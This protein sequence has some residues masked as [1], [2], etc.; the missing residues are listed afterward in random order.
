MIKVGHLPNFDVKTGEPL[1]QTI[2]TPD[3]GMVKV[4]GDSRLSPQVVA[5]VNTIK[6]TDKHTYKLITAMG[7]AE[8]WGQNRNGDRFYER[9]LLLPGPKYGHT[10]FLS[11]GVYRHHVNKDPNKSLG[12]VIF[13]YYNHQMHRVELVIDYDHGLLERHGAMDYLSLTNPDYS[14]AARVPWDRCTICNDEALFRKVLAGAVSRR[15]EDEVRAVLDYIKHTPIK[16]LATKRPDYCDHLKHM[17]NQIIETGPDAGKQVGSKNDYPEFFDIS[18]VTT[19]ADPSAKEMRKIASA[20]EYMGGAELAEY[21]G[22]ADEEPYTILTK[23]ASWTD[24]LEIART[25][26]KRAADKAAMLEHE[27]D[28]DKMVDGVGVPLSV[29]QER[30]LPRELLGNGDV[31]RL[32]STLGG[33]GIVLNPMEFQTMSLDRMGMGGLGSFLESRNAVFPPCPV[34]GGHAANMPWVSPSSV[35]RGLADSFLPFLENRSCLTPVSDRRMYAIFVKTAGTSVHD[36]VTYTDAVQMAPELE[37]TMSAVGSMYRAYRENLASSVE[38]LVHSACGFSSVRDALWGDALEKRAVSTVELA[39][40]GSLFPI[41]YLY[42]AH[43]RKEEQ[44]G[45]RLGLIRDFLK[46]HPM[47]SAAAVAGMLKTLGYGAAKSAGL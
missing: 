41:M 42:A 6:P 30:R 27:A 21:Y 4:A 1:V 20:A 43:L 9:A 16:G 28:I 12:K 22:C 5:F 38:P 31:T 24:A 26:V 17:M 10:S 36:E 25:H 46:K 39:A 11:A 19:G 3:M 44:S 37:K 18:Q 35:D 45:E 15:P 2:W 7:A 29:G 32:L 14:M 34:C 8:Y 33:L 40:L 13:A 23:A 47:I